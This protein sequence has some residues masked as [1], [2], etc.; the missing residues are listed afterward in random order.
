MSLQNSPRIAVAP[1]K[2]VRVTD[3][4]RRALENSIDDPTY[5]FENHCRTQD[6]HRQDLRSRP[7]PKCSEQPY[8]Y[9]IIEY[10]HTRTR[11]AIPKSRQMMLSWTVVAYLLWA[12][13]FHRNVWTF[14]VSLKRSHASK[15]VSRAK[16]IY[17]FQGFSREALGYVHTIQTIRKDMGTTY[18]FPFYPPRAEFDAGH[19]H[20][21]SL[22]EGLSQD[23][24]EIRMN[25]ATFVMYDEVAFQPRAM[26]SHRAIHPALGD[27]GTIIDVSSPNGKN[28]FF[29]MVHDLEGEDAVY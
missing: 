14:F 5:W 13:Q 12:T 23:P 20:Q 8:L 16:F 7:F 4:E 15:L 27:T 26:E 3:A 18:T 28:H 25:T 21:M 11:I 24:E 9:K 1:K 17:R 10:I 29:L 2:I 19:R 6:Q 22:I